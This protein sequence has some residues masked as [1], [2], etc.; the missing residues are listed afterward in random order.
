M[1]LDRIT[2][3]ESPSVSHAF[4]ESIIPAAEL[5]LFLR[6]Y[7]TFMKLVSWKMFFFFFKEMLVCDT[8]YNKCELFFKIFC[9][10]HHNK[11]AVKTKINHN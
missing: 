1:C 9:S 5:G 8:K 10:K 6:F 2:G 11:I 7:R 4:V 3:A